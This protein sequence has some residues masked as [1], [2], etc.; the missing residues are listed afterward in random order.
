MEQKLQKISKKC[1]V[2]VIRNEIELPLS[3]QE[4]DCKDQKYLKLQ[5][6]SQKCN[7]T[8]KRNAIELSLSDQEEDYKYQKYQKK[9]QKCAS[10]G[11]IFTQSSYLKKH[12]EDRETKNNSDS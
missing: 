11:K 2:T 1:N 7:V 5:E 10:C 3:D 9:Y 4:E 8:V 6:I 12:I